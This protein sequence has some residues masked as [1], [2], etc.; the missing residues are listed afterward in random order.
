MDMITT[1]ITRSV[2]AVLCLTVIIGG[3]SFATDVG[4]ST[5]DL[6]I[7]FIIRFVTAVLCH[8]VILGGK[9]SATDV[10][11]K[12]TAAVLLMWE[13]QVRYVLIGVFFRGTLDS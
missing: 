12:C 5:M 10:K 8:T 9:I 1:V 7:I 3:Q 13:L 2:T 11:M 4:R 6:I